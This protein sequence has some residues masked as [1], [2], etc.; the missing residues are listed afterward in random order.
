MT[1]VNSL[2]QIKYV[3]AV[4][5]SV[6]F[7]CLGLLV[8]FSENSG[9]NSSA[10]E[11]L[12]TYPIDISMAGIHRHSKQYVE[13]KQPSIDIKV[14]RDEMMYNHFNLEIKTENFEFTPENISENHVKNEGHAHVYVDDVMIS[15][16]Y[17][18][19]Y[20]L[21]RLEKGNHTIKVTLNTNN[22]KEY[23]SENGVIKDELSIEVSK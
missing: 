12:E 17:G 18:N 22:H 14:H 20:H 23:Q 10:Q 1:E 16:S 21:P 15:R 11:T 7:L 19:W 3:N 6:T 5:I 2:L 9:I 8:G 13:K 4:L